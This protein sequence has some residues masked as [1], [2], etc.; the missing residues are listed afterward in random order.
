MTLLDAPLSLDP[1]DLR[2]VALEAQVGG[3]R[4]IDVEIG[5]AAIECK[6]SLTVAAPKLAEWER[7]LAGYVRDRTAQLDRR[8]VGVLTDGTRW[9]LYHLTPQ[10]DRDDAVLRREDRRATGT[11]PRRPCPQK[12]RERAGR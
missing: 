5:S 4:R 7:Q 2:E 1:D 3:G 12:G 8:Y 6:K 11:D 9:R 10:S